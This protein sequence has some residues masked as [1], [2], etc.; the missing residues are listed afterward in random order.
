MIRSRMKPYSIE[1]R[2]VGVDDYGQPHDSFYVLKTVDVSV[3]LL[4]NTLNESDVRY[5]DSTHL[6]LTF[7]KTLKD[8]MRIT[9]DNIHY[10]IKLVN[11]DGRMS[12]LTLQEV[13]I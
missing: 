10:M 9:S 12:Q 8:G 3:T 5:V 1:V 7:D 4:T 6:G 2:N 11:N 13:L